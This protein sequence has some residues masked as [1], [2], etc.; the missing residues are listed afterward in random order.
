MRR[1]TISIPIENISPQL[2]YREPMMLLRNIGK[3]F[4]DVSSQSSADFPRSLGWPRH[5]DRRS[6]TTTDRMD[7][8]VTDQRRPGARSAQYNGDREPL[9]HPQ[10][11]RP[12]EQPRRHWRG[13]EGRHS[14]WA[15]VGHRDH[16]G[17]YLSASDP[18]LHF[19]LGATRRL[20]ALRFAGPAES[21]K[22]CSTRPAIVN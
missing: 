15:A 1:G 18:R 12:Q 4:V 17:G 16:L 3:N 13:G 11:H 5:G 6:S 22:C 8:V 7:A 2:H 20:S 21:S 19:G 9:A 10:A 14:A